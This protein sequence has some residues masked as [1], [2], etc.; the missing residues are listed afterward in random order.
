MAVLM[1]AAYVAAADRK[2]DTRPNVIFIL[3]D[4]LG[5]G[6]LGCYGHE[7]IKSP[8][9]DQ[10]AKQGTLYT[11]FYSNA[12]V[13]S[14]S[15]CAFLTGQYPARHRIHGHYVEEH[16]QNAN[17]GMSDWLD[18]KVSNVGSML[19]SA[20]YATGHFGKWH[21]GHT[22]G[23]PAIS[24]YGFDD[25]RAVLCK[26]DGWNEPYD[27]FWP[28]C[29]TLFVD[30]TIRFI[31]A[32]KDK[33]FYVNVWTLL[34]HAPLNP[35][36]EQ[37][38]PF[39]Y[40]NP[41]GGI[42][43]KSATTIYYASVWDLDTQVGRLLD[44]LNKLDLADNTIVVFSS[45]NG[46][47]DIYLP[48]AGHCGV[49]STG[50]FR[51][52][53]R[54]LYEGG[55]RMPF[56]VRWP[57][58]VSAG[59]VDDTS[60]VA[61]VDLLPSLCKLIGIQLPAGHALDGEDASDVLLGKARPRKTDLMWEW[62]YWIIGDPVNRSPML[63]IREGDYKLLMNPDHSRVELYDIPRD[64]TQVDNLAREHPDVV[65]QLATKLLAWQ[66]SL[67]PGSVESSAGKVD[68]HWPG[69]QQNTQPKRGNAGR[70]GYK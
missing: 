18:P 52:R 3:A 14:P 9:L 58:H 2:T 8:R 50:P 63:A 25:S 51:G 39:N 66:K 57:G 35:T 19:K 10:L 21:L 29:T 17:R 45:D 54:S 30:E 65:E 28:K 69:K 60:V 42:P 44:E 62:R 41:G 16:D 4:D 37:M 46:P 40:C 11:Q 47:E 64:P 59:R 49:G 6:D 31:R 61:A 70:K 34:P 23:V 55:I 56:I 36:D 48:E 38:K 26:T 68:Y 67:P 5:W 33:P 22:P 15:R 24:E 20:G 12:S 13:C 27:K 43:H 7:R 32:N 1:S 53:K